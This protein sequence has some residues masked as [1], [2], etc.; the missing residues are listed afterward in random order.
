MS[1]PRTAVRIG[2]DIGGTKIHGVAAD[3]ATGAVLAETRTASRRGPGG[4]VASALDIVKRLVDELPD[5]TSLL[6]VGVGVPG[7]VD[8]RGVLTNA[9]NL[10]VTAPLDLA[11]EL[12][13]AL[14]VPVTVNNDVN[15]A[16]R[17]AAT[18]LAGLGE[19]ED[20]ALLSVGTG[21]AAG[22]VLGGR[23]RRGASGLVGEIGH[24]SVQPDG[25]RCSCGQNGCLELY[26]SGSGL[27]R[28]WPYDGSVPAPVALF[29]AADTGDEAAI[30]IRS[31]FIGWLS[32]AIR[33]ATL[34]VDPARVVLTGGVMRL[35]D[36]IMEP[37]FE[38]LDVDETASPFVASLRLRERTIALP[39]DHP[40]AALGAAELSVGSDR[41]DT[42]TEG[43]SPWRS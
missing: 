3:A 37:L 32:E 17:G 42:T 18:W 15:A 2:L 40:A 13:S 28:Q 14:S 43:E 20:V 35:G 12:T 25:P 1:A 16:A 6:S 23:V 36:R 30:A 34:S 9:V 38:R 22:F 7:A 41:D 24:L 26:A 31:S 8:A 4:V 27:A 33:I 19:P 5:D 10:D 29:D 39:P 11:G 21:L